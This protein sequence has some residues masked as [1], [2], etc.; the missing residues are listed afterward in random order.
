MKIRKPNFFEIYG[1]KN[2]EEVVLIEEAQT[3]DVSVDIVMNQEEICVSAKAE[4]TP[5]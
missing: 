2:G 5:I 4:K 3:H 1:Q